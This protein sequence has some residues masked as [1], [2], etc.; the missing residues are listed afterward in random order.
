MEL[1]SA[2]Q[3]IKDIILCDLD[4][5]ADRVQVFWKAGHVLIELHR[6]NIIE[7]GT[8]T[9]S[10]PCQPWFERQVE[11]W[12]H[13]YHRSIISAVDY[14]SIEELHALLV[15]EQAE[16]PKIWFTECWSCHVGWAVSRAW[17]ILRWQLVF[18]R[19]DRRLM[20][21]SILD[22][23]LVSLGNPFSD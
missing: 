13:Q 2:G 20:C 10:W 8:A 21:V 5:S 15:A 4:S 6:I 17:W 3:I 9:L 7:M 23:K 22:W 1:I 12:Y 14:D 19:H 11:T 16:A 18:Q